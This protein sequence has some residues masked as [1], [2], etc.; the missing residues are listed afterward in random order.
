MWP[1]GQQ[2]Q[3]DV[4]HATDRSTEGTNCPVEITND[5]SL[6]PLSQKIGDMEVAGKNYH[7]F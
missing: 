1:A 6:V 7:E 4:T 5:E 2:V 3:F